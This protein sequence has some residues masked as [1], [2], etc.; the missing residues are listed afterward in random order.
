MTSDDDDKVK[1]KYEC[2][3]WGEKIPRIHNDTLMK[4]AKT[5]ESIKS[6]FKFNC[7]AF[8]NIFHLFYNA[9]NLKIICTWT[10]GGRGTAAVFNRNM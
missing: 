6:R 9:L 4:T 10:D 3:C 8:L 5:M 1:W 2:V 7:K